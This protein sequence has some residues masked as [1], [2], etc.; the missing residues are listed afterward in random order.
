MNVFANRD[1]PVGRLLHQMGNQ[2]FAVA[3]QKVDDGDFNHGVTTRLLLHGCTIL[4]LLF[5]LSLIHHLLLV[6]LVMFIIHLFHH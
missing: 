3:V 5:V 6:V 1:K 4:F 2:F